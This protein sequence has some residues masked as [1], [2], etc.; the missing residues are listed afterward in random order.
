[1]NTTIANKKILLSK[2][3]MKE[4]KKSVI[5][6]G[7]DLRK[8]NQSLRELDKSASRD[9]HLSRIDKISAIQ[10]FETDLTEKRLIL[11]S[12]KLIPAKRNRLQVTIGSVVELI[13][14]YGRM[15]RYTIVDSVEAN[16]SDGRISTASPLGQSLIGKTIKDIIEWTNGIKTNQ[17]QLVNIF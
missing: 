8:A 16:P 15:F 4:L 11:A 13:D 7:H 12:A 3:G 10:G 1:M 2:K 17:L 5:Q 9:T 14:R 6:L